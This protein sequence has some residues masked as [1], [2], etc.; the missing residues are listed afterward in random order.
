[1]EG[2]SNEAFVK[3]RKANHLCLKYLSQIKTSYLLNDTCFWL[4]ET[5]KHESSNLKVFLEI[6]EYASDRI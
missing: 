4:L 1:M 2:V 6:P 3:P 5:A